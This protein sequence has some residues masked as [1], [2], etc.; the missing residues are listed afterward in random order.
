MTNLTDDQAI[1]YNKIA[2]ELISTCYK[3]GLHDNIAVIGYFLVLIKQ[4]K[5]DGIE[6]GEINYNIRLLGS[7]FLD[8]QNSFDLS[9]FISNSEGPKLI[10]SFS[11][12]CYFITK[13]DL[14]CAILYDA[15]INISAKE[16]RHHG[17]YFQPKE[18][19]LLIDRLLPDTTKIVY[20]PF[21]GIASYQIINSSRKIYGQEIKHHAW[22]IG[23]I[24]LLLNNINSDYVCEN[25]ISNWKGITEKFDAVIST[26]PFGCRIDQNIYKYNNISNFIHREYDSFY[27]DN[28]LNSITPNGIVAS[29][30]SLAF[31]LRGNSSTQQFKRHIIGNGYVQKVILLPSNIFYGTSIKT[32]VVILTRTPNDGVVMVDGSN[33]FEKDRK[34]V[35]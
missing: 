2:K 24:R 19:S 17:E 35:V 22:I 18:V 31:L 33:F 8:E 13:S 28:A 23:K 4:G 11:T 16:S 14:D 30:V 15:V 26:P 7:V 12:I 5:F 6:D 29:I 27:L 1:F 10:K 21:A 25:S 9:D 34:S 20:N 3:H 32:A